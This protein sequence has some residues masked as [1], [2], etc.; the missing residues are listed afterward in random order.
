[1]R[2]AGKVEIPRWAYVDVTEEGNFDADAPMQS[3]RLSVII[4]VGLL[5]TDD[6]WDFLKNPRTDGP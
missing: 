3:E 5:L 2:T 1:M 6:S 4:V